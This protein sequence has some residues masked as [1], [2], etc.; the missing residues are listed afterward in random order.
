MV[1]SG[2]IG[3]PTVILMAE[4][5]F[6]YDLYPLRLPMVHR[7]PFGAH[8]PNGTTFNGD[9]V[10]DKDPIIKSSKEICSIRAGV[11]RRI[12]YTTSNMGV[13][14]EYIIY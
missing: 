6:S 4:V 9:N 1:V 2:N 8:R 12:P 5:S 13:I 11:T 10:G 7:Q 3:D 14:N